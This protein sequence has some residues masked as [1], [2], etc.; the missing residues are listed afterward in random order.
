M[1][2]DLPAL[3]PSFRNSLGVTLEILR[4]RPLAEAL[5]SG[6]SRLA[7]QYAN[8]PAERVFVRMPLGT[9]VLEAW[10]SPGNQELEPLSW[11][12]SA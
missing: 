8:G 11:E 12:I 1:E 9:G 7:E 2:R 10:Y 6:L 3:D 4:Q 5:S